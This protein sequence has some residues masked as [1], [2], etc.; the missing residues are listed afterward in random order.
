MPRKIAPVELSKG[1]CVTCALC[2]DPHACAK[3]TCAHHNLWLVQHLQQVVKD[4]SVKVR[5]LNQQLK[6]AQNG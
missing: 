1:A 4:L 6:G 3:A 5:K 2:G